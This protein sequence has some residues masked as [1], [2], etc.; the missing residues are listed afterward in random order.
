[1]QRSD[2]IDPEAI[3]REVRAYASEWLRGAGVKEEPERWAL[4]L[5]RCVLRWERWAAAAFELAWKTLFVAML[6]GA[7]GW[8]ATALQLWSK[9]GW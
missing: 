3:R 4:D 6:L 1:M 9:V 8:M 2:D 7:A 5:M